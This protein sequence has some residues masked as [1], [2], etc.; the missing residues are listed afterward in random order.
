MLNWFARRALRRFSKRYGYDTTY[1][2]EMLEHAP[3]AFYK[4]ALVQAAASHRKRVPVDALFAVKLVASSAADCGPCTQLAADMAAE[5]GMNEQQIAAVLGGRREELDANVLLAYDFARAIAAHPERQ[6]ET[7]AAVAERWGTAGVVE[8]GLGF[9]M[10]QV[11]PRL[12]G[13]L[14]HAASCSS[15]RVGERPVKLVAHVG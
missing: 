11:F 15:V 13:A 1:L 4:F 14:G 9:V 5:A 3:S 8:L 2:A 12:K 6:L 7:R 10:A